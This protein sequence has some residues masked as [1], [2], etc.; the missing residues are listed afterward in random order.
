MTRLILASG[1]PRR[2]ELLAQLGV[3]F[4]VIPANIDETPVE[5]D[6][7]RLAERLALEKARAVASKLPRGDD[8]AVLGA[9]T[10]VALDGRVLGKP[11]DAAE[12]R[13]MLGAL[14]GR[15]HE[16]IT[17]LALV[18]SDRATIEAVRTE[19]R[20][21]EYTNTEIEAY[22]A[23]AALEDGPYDKA[24]A[25]AIQDATFHP[26][27]EAIGCVCSVI[28]LPLWRAHSMLHSTHIEAAAPTIERCASCP[29]PLR[30]LRSGF[31]RAGRP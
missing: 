13:E 27:A 3:P 29:L 6:P 7:A 26:V 12:A 14:R 23:R 16:V 18:V 30:D 28:G 4:D 5:A 31:G 1:S 17:G 22:V 15:T 21:R 2:R 11:R 19:V 20:M 8:A 10:V 25:Y 24:G 9:D